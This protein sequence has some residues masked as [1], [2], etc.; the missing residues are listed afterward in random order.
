MYTTDTFSFLYS[1]FFVCKVWSDLQDSILNC[2]HSPDM[3][4]RGRKDAYHQEVWWGSYSDGLLRINL[5][6]L[7]RATR[8]IASFPYSVLLFLLALGYALLFTAMSTIS[9]F[10]DKCIYYKRE[11]LSLHAPIWREIHLFLVIQQDISAYFRKFSLVYRRFA[12]FYYP[13]R[14]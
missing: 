11:N 12:K 14:A 3:R 10:R 13:I 5:L 8:K 4:R 2:W 7:T 9:I 1:L 6:S